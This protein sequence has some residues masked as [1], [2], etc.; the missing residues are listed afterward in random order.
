MHLTH[1]M[2]TQLH[3][4]MTRHAARYWPITK[5][6]AGKS[7]LV[8]DTF[9]TYADVGSVGK[10]NPRRGYGNLMDHIRSPSV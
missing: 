6:T 4:M 8:S 3:L 2:H 9:Y 10:Q 5:R 1:L 7:R